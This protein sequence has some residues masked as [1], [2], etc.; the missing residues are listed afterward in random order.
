MRAPVTVLLSDVNSEPIL[1]MAGAALTT[2]VT[3]TVSIPSRSS[4][5][6]A[7]AGPRRPARSPPTRLAAAAADAGPQ[8]VAV[9]AA[10]GAEGRGS[11]TAGAWNGG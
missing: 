8:A 9:A 2:F 11:R 7:A 10:L 1:L 4:A 3:V 5:A 6:A